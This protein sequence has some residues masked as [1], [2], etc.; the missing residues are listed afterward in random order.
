[1][2]KYKTKLQLKTNTIRVLQAGELT[3]V[4]GGQAFRPS[5]VPTHCSATL[6][7]ELNVAGEE[8]QS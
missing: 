6:Y 3:E 1:M 2:R 5:I 4:R 8:D 7:C